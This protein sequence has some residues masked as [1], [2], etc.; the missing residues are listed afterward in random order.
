MKSM[1]TVKALSVMNLVILIM[2]VSVPGASKAVYAD[3]TAYY[4]D[5]INGNDANNGQS[6]SSAW[7]TVTKVNG[8]TFKPGDRILF[9]AGGIWSGELWPKGSGT[10]GNP[11]KIDMYG[12]GSK[13]AFTGSQTAN[14]T[15]HLDNQEYWEI[16][17]LDISANYTDAFTRRGIYVHANDYGTVNHLYFKNLVIHDVWPNIAHTN[18]N[19]AKDTGGMFFSITGGTTVTKFNDILIENNTIRDLDRE[20][21]TL[22]WTTWSNRQGET[23]GSGPW[24]GSTNV[25]VRNNYFTNIGGDGLVAQGLQSPL[26]EYNTIDGFNKRNYN[27]SY[28]AGLWAYSAD[29]AVFQYNEATN[30]KST[31]D[32]MAWDADA[33]TNRAVFQY[34]Y[35][36]DNEGGSMLFISYGTEY[37]RDAV[38]RYNIS[39]N[40]RNFLITA[41]NP[42]NAS[43]Y[44]NVF[45]TQSG[46][47]AKVF[48]TNSGTASFKNNIFYNQGTTSTSSWGSGYTY[49]NNVFYGNYSTTPNDAS[50]ITSDPLFVNPGAGATGRNTLAG[51]QLQSTSP[52]INSGTAVANNGGKDFWGNTLY[53]GNPDRG[54]YEHQSSVSTPVN[55]A[56]GKTVS[57]GSF[58]NNPERVTDGQSG[59]KEQYAGLDGGLQWLAM[60]LGA[61]YNVSRIKLWHY[62]DGRS[63]RDV[64]V[65]LS[66]NPDFTSGVTTV[67]NNDANN[68][69]GLGAGTDAEYAETSS[70][71]EITFSPVQA[72]YIRFWSNGSS[73]NQWNHVVEAEVYGMSTP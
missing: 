44:N 62:F 59:N 6:E 12:T 66:S 10:S 24:T 34:N 39:Q 14:Q 11:I 47:S 73:V 58:V 38:Y 29:D 40:D 68:S 52:A 28:N 36:H 31:R 70:G 26:I 16:S 25:V 35:S 54:A 46:V 56:L 63:Y 2:A 32:G 43:I 48:N 41:T 7:K 53:V 4:V 55:V 3:N 49:S 71:K 13:P 30:G 60:D 22:T 67:F 33:R 65:Q 27:V 19:T 69:A 64:I 37:S 1:M 15:L 45:Y 5:A 18:N 17:N 51:Y 23:G 61:A 50:K 8:I 57:S 20:G 9:K 21:I 42:I 72:R